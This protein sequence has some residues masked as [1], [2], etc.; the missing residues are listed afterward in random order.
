MLTPEPM[1][2]NDLTL[3]HEPTAIM[4]N[5]EVDFP[6]RAKFLRLIDEPNANVSD[7]EILALSRPNP[8][9]LIDDARL[10]KEHALIWLP[11][12]AKLLTET[13]DPTFKNLNTLTVPPMLT[14]PLNTEIPEPIRAKC[15]MLM[16]LLRVTKLSTERLLPMLPA[17]LTLIV[18]PKVS[19][20]I[21]LALAPILTLTPLVPNTLRPEP[22]RANCL[23][24]I[25]LPIVAM[26]STLSLPPQRAVDRTLK[27]LDRWQ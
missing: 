11:R 20:S 21:I 24:L 19:L 18:E 2:Q 23:T 15:L 14:V 22:T 6:K 1:R 26:L 3:M 8:R 12:R 4:S 7:I 25:E 5:T 9:M 16:Q 10:T 13:H 17:D 27:L